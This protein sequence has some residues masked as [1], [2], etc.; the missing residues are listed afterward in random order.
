MG[1]RKEEGHGTRAIPMAKTTFAVA[2]VAET[3]ME[4]ICNKGCSQG[5][6]ELAVD[7][8]PQSVAVT[9]DHPDLLDTDVE[10][11]RGR[12]RYRHELQL[13]PARA[14]SAVNQIRIRSVHPFGRSTLIL[15]SLPPEAMAPVDPEGSSNQDL[16]SSCCHG[17]R[18]TGCLSAIVLFHYL[19]T[20]AIRNSFLPTPSS[21]RDLVPGPIEPP[22]CRHLIIDPLAKGMQV[23]DSLHL[24][25][26]I[27]N[28]FIILLTS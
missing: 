26:Q 23:E 7:D 27:I 9:G 20:L 1:F 13:R 18:L 22:L 2:A 6:Q 24:V 25:P 14:A 12:C 3:E 28:R 17:A 11:R 5:Q 10:R 21:L 15:T 4:W 19:A 16:R 8:S